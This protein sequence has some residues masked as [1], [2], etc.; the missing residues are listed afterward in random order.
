MSQRYLLSCTCGKTIPVGI[1]QAG[2]TVTC[3]C[4]QSLAVPTIRGLKTLPIEAGSSA[5][6]VKPAAPSE[7]NGINLQGA[8]FV[9][10]LLLILA[11]LGLG[12]YNGWLYSQIDTKNYDEE[13][14]AYIGGEIDKLSP[15]Q[16]LETWH[17][18]EEIGIGE[19]IPATHIVAQQASQSALRL[20]IA[21]GA[22]VLAGL[23]CVVL[24]V[25]A[26]GQTRRRT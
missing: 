20:A 26:G 17:K 3:S 8:M 5:A 12:G 15:S 9:L 1:S 18:L 14:L 4:G 16:M 21:G 10:G 22:M 11:G 7:I 25:A 19:Y 6:S 23:V 2:S 13:V 24:S